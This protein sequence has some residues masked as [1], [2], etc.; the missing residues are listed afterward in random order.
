MGEMMTGDELNLLFENSFF[1]KA[2]IKMLLGTG[3]LEAP[4]GLDRS[5]VADNNVV[6]HINMIDAAS[7]A[8][9]GVTLSLSSTGSGYWIPYLGNGIDV[10]TADT[11]P[12]GLGTFTP[13][14]PSGS[15]ISWVATGPFSGCR[16]VVFKPSAGLVFAHVITP[17]SGT[18]CASV[19][20]QVK[21]ISSKLGCL[22]PGDGIVPEYT[23][24]AG[25]AFWL[26]IQGQWYYRELQAFNGIVT[27]VGK[28][29]A[30]S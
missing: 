20:D 30:V 14:I 23:T 29:Q 10:S 8:N 15:G 3:K 2:K 27:A 6:E 7:D 28:K 13:P 16:A 21:S 24:G 4:V 17:A 9:G 18:E 22:D 1:C 26:R 5:K 19:R 11:V 25:Y 12:R